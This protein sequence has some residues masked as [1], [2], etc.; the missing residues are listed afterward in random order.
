[1]S[2]EKLEYGLNAVRLAAIDAPPYAHET[3]WDGQS[4]CASLV[5]LFLPTKSWG[6]N[7]EHVIVAHLFRLCP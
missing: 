3:R 1:M 4:E 6:G 5:N 7:T 2:A